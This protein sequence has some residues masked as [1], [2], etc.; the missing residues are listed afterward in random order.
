[1]CHRRRLSI[2]KLQHFTKFYFFRM[3]FML[4][5]SVHKVK[6]ETNLTLLCT[7]SHIYLS[8]WRCFGAPFWELSPKFY[9]ASLCKLSEYLKVMAVTIL[10]A[11]AKWKA[12]CYLRWILLLTLLVAVKWFQIIYR[13]IWWQLTSDESWNT[14]LKNSTS[15]SNVLKILIFYCWQ[16]EG[17]SLMK[18]LSLHIIVIELSPYMSSQINF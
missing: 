3:C 8:Q 11:L 4:L 15:E 12:S 13:R 1:M 14:E 5:N 16:G 9:Y 6:C 18:T 10:I 2:V 7:S 17:K